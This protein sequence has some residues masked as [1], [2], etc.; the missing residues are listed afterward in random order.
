VPI[1]PWILGQALA[2]THGTDTLVEEVHHSEV[3]AAA[4]AE[5]VHHSEVVA[6]DLAEEIHH[7]E[8]VAVEAAHHRRAEE[9]DS[10]IRLAR[11]P[12]M[13]TRSYAS[14]TFLV[15]TSSTVTS[16]SL[17]TGVI[18]CEER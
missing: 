15:S 17:L 5:E 14:K 11:D 3:V 8:V 4:L 6:A 10:P 16:P 12:G 18:G 2:E 7:L 9:L 13:P 1:F